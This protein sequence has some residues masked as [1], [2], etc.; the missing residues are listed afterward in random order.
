M[1]HMSSSQIAAR[2][3]EATSSIL[4]MW[5]NMRGAESYA[6]Q[7]PCVIDC[8][9]MPH[10]QVPRIVLKDCLYVEELDYFL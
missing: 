9:C 10:Y 5:E 2:R 4:S 8:G 1:A 3:Q 7:C 6:L